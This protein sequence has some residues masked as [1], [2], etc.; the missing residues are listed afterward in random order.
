[1]KSPI[2]RYAGLWLM[3]IALFVRFLFSL[4]PS[5]FEQFYFNGLFRY[6]RNFQDGFSTWLPIS[7]YAILIL[8]LLVWLIWRRPT[9]WKKSKSWLIFGRRLLN[10]MGGVVFLFLAL[11][12]YNYLDRGL[13]ERLQ[14]KAA[15][16]RAQLAQAYLDCMDRAMERRAAIPGIMHFET[17]EDWDQFP[18]DT[19]INSWLENELSGLGYPTDARIRVRHIRPDGVL[20]RMSISG[21]Y[22]PFTGEAN[23]DN[24][25]G[26]LQKVFTIAHE[27]A[28]GYGITGEAEANFAAYLACLRS[29][30]PMAAYAAEYVLW[31][32]LA[33]EV[34]K[35]YPQ[36]T[37]LALAARIPEVLQKDREA[38]WKNY[39]RYK[40]YFPEITNTMNDAYLKVQGVEAGADDYDLFVNLWFDWAAQT[41]E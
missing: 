14:L 20:R 5:W 26:P 27:L 29:G 37:V 34:N 11:W 3:F 32:H 1:M 17:I 41:T 21:I 10:L 16:D 9:P 24:A 4:F 2:L 39:Y 13:G 18:A 8:F 35:N 33:S 31:R 38:I 7:G 12:G 36:E 23:V 22:N 6:I 30:N 40:G 28:H 25:L 15:T 19:T